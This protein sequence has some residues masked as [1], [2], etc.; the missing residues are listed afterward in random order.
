MLLG[1]KVGLQMAKSNASVLMLPMSLDI[2]GAETHVISLS[3]GMQSLG[4]QVYVASDGGQRVRDLEE[5]G[6]PHFAAPLHSRSP[7]SMVRAYQI[8]SR[9]LDTHRIDL[10][11]AHARIPIWISEKISNKRNIPLV[12]TYH[13][14]FKSG[15]PWVFFSRQGDWTIAVSQIIRDYIV[16]EFGFDPEKI[17]VIPNGID[18]SL[19]HP[20]NP[21]TTIRA[22]QK[23]G[24]PE[25]TGP[26]LAYA[27]RLE[28]DLASAAI[29]AQDAVFELSRK[30][31]GIRLLIAGNGKD[32]DS[33]EAR[34][35]EI[36]NATG[37]E[38]IRCL[39]F[40]LDTPS[41]YAASDIVVGM[42][43]VAL[44][45]MASGKPVVV[46]GP[47]G[48]FGPAS[49]DNF[50]VLEERNYVSLNAPFPPTTK[51]LLE[52][53]DILIQDPKKW[54]SFGNFGRQ[55]VVEYHSEE[56]VARATERLY[57]K[58]LGK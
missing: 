13:Y 46:F 3:K 11:H 16:R 43:R 2:G 49:P 51:A 23:L 37:K 15:F 29:V 52:P 19:F 10:I 41:L 33:V 39:G 54:A 34:A 47:G 58:L 7:L 53:I 30:Y 24:I 35:A 56:S 5:A 45:A 32:F 6:I 27:S 4:W 36:N 50:S 18:V 9:I 14:P 57:C 40:V 38:I 22:R 21:E 44:E 12:T 1:K 26:V 17:T 25:D 42:S 20:A 48:V 55:T 31:P 8:I 28:G